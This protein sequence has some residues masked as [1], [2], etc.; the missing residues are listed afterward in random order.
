MDRYKGKSVLITGG[1]SGM[2]LATAKLFVGEGARV[3][4][5]GR[6]PESVEA[7]QAELGENAIA[8]QS[9]ATSFS[10]MDSLAEKARETFDKLD[11]LF[12]NAGISRRVSFE[13]TTE[14]IYDELL[15]LNA[16]GRR[17]R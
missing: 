4:V 5:T 3:M 8:V 12:S 14:D 16:K 17:R 11:L 10:D 7:A 9:D 2:G 6:T 1:T 13:E 15:D